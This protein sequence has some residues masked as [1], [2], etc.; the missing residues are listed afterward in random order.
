MMVIFGHSSGNYTQWFSGENTTMYDRIQMK[1]SN[2]K[3]KEVP[4]WIIIIL[5]KA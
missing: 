1:V 2:K 5:S 4:E 3:Q